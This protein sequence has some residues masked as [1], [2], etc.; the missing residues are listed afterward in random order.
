MKK[1]FEIPVT[2]E[3]VKAFMDEWDAELLP[4][5]PI[6]NFWQRCFMYLTIPYHFVILASQYLFYPANVNP[7]TTKS[8]V[9]TGVKKGYFAK[10]YSVNAV[11]KASKDHKVTVNDLIMTAISMTI[12]QY[13]LTKGDEK[14]NQI[15]VFT[16]Y[17]LRE[18]PASVSDFGFVNQMAVFPVKLRLVNDFKTGVQA[19][20]R[21]LRPLRTSFVTFAMYYIIRLNQSFP[22]LLSVFSFNQFANKC[23]L[24]TTNVHGPSIPYVIG[25]VKSLKAATFMP[26]LGDVPG[27]FAIISHLDVLWVSFSAD[28]SR[29]DDAKQIITIFENT[30]DSIMA[31]K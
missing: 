31:G 8:K 19:I 1:L 18:K 4:H 26:N 17:N 24:I 9:N 28:R 25:G 29:C 10:D 27:G 16:P 20:S 30:M 23:S 21:D 13:F 12:K 3:Q 22:T 5:L 14:T 6:F 7:L 2:D 15:L 11:K